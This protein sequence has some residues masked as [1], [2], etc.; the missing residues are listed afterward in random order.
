MTPLRFQLSKTQQVW[1]SFIL[2]IHKKQN[3]KM[4]EKQEN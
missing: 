1:K 3:L 4:V 2:M